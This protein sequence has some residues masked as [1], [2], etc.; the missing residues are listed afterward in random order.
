MEKQGSSLNTYF[1]IFIQVI[2]LSAV[3]FVLSFCRP[4]SVLVQTVSLI[5]LCKTIII[6]EFFLGSAILLL[7]TSYDIPLCHVKVSFMTLLMK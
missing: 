1:V 3:S 4:E 6:G 7:F 2:T 5:I